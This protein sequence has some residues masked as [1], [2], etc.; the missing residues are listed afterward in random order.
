MLQ[1]CSRP[2]WLAIS[3]LG[4]VLDTAEVKIIS[5]QENNQERTIKI[6]TR[7]ICWSS[8]VD[9]RPGRFTRSLSAQSGQDD[10]EEL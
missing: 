5:L 6:I 4:A 1:P 2:T 10:D 3:I 8:E 9:Q 7:S